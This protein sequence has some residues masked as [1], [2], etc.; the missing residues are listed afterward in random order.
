MRLWTGYPA[1]SENTTLYLRM[2]RL[3][4][5]D[6]QM[7][8]AIKYADPKSGHWPVQVASQF[9]KIAFDCVSSDPANRPK[10]EEVVERLAKMQEEH[11]KQEPVVIP[12]E[13]KCCVCMMQSVDCMLEPCKHSVA[14]T[15]CSFE[16]I[17]R[18][19]TGRCPICK[20]RVTE[21]SELTSQTTSSS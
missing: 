6:K 13:E 11:F 16:M 18:S 4:K 5:G 15:D 9:A 2:K 7:T 12:E 10:M 21:L 14:C 1:M 8:S 19:G 20:K 17:S 3:M